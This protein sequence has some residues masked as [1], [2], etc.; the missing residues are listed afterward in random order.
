MA[1]LKERCIEDGLN[2]EKDLKNQFIAHLNRGIK[3][4]YD[5]NMKSLND[6]IDLIP[7]EIHKEFKSKVEVV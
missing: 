1:L 4:I 7:E 3:S 5:M 2:P 6:I